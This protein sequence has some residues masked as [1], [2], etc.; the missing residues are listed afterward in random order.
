MIGTHV[1]QPAAD[2][3]CCLK[4]SSMADA[5]DVQPETCGQQPA[6]PPVD[7]QTSLTLRCMQCELPGLSPQVSL[8]S[9]SVGP[10]GGHADSAG[11]FTDALAAYGVQQ[12]SCSGLSTPQLQP[13]LALFNAAQQA[14]RGLLI[15]AASCEAPEGSGRKLPHKRT[16]NLLYKVLIQTNAAAV[17]ALFSVQ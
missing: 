1:K 12:K 5:S 4:A 17:A 11:Q 9:L 2:G 16:P 13:I 15:R 7:L 14:K 10:S 3:K 8:P 6:L